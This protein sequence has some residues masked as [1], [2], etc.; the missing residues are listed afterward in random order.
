MT[1][2]GLG[3]ENGAFSLAEEVLRE[4]EKYSLFRQ[5]FESLS[6]GCQKLLR[7]AWNG[8]PLQEV[9]A[10]MNISYG[11][12]RKKKCECIARLTDAIQ[13][14]PEFHDFNRSD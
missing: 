9:A 12:A 10:E 4:E 14:A 13:N 6:E 5:K 8:R 3:D 11:Y 1:L 7:L 2:Q